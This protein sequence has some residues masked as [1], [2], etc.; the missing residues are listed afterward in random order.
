MRSALTCFVLAAVMAACDSD[1]RSGAAGRT[2]DSEMPMTATPDSVTAML[3]GPQSARL[4]VPVTFVLRVR[5]EAAQTTTLYLRGREIAFDVVLTDTNG[6]EIWSRLHDQV[7]QAI[8][9]VEQVDPGQ[10]IELRHTWNQHDNLGRPA[11]P[12]EYN[13]QGLVL[14]DGAPIRT[15]ARRMRI[16]P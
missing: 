1:H 2:G 10:S 7:V 6:R 4:G 8:V 11:R 3:D 14:T 13:V 15:P 12:G 16:L 5:N 9:R